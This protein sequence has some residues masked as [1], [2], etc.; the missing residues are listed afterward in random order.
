MLLIHQYALFMKKTLLLLWFLSSVLLSQAQLSEATYR[1]GND[2]LCLKDQHAMFH[3]SG[4]AGLSVAQVG[5]GKYEQLGDILVVHTGEYSGEK[6]SSRTLPSSRKD[7]CMV[8]VV[9][10]NNYPLYP[11]LVESYSKSGKLLEGK[12]TSQE[13]K[14]FLSETEKIGSIVV[15]ALGYH[16]HRMQYEPELDYRVQLAENE[17]IE[18]R[19]VV[20]RCN[21]IDEET[22]SL[23]ML[24]DDFKAGKNRDRELQK[25][26]KKARR[27]NK[28][29]KRMKKV[30]VPYERKF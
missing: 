2:S 12:V 5:E 30:Y 28:I 29:D 20:F 6:S 15:S 4:F 1:E 14:L 27:N 19:E 7:S 21:I 11:I 16:T 23:L 18:N 24:S 10:S 25:L 9:G 8:E 13:G 26:L 22:I 3:L 17:I